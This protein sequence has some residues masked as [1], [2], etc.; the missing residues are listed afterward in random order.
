VND[1]RYAF[2]TVSLSTRQSSI[3]SKRPSSFE[4][5]NTVDLYRFLDET[6]DSGGTR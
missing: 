3:P 2:V 5:I 6:H 1:V 4:W